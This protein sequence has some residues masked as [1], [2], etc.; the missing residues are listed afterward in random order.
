MSMSRSLNSAI[1]DASTTI[2]GVGSL[3]RNKES[4]LLKESNSILDEMQQTLDST[5][6]PTDQI[7]I[8]AVLSG[9]LRRAAPR[10]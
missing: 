9:D 10:R 5:P 4:G 1:E 2:N 8:L 3:E 6:I 7:A